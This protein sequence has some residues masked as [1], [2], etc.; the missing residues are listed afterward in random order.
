MYFHNRVFYFNDW[1]SLG[2]NVFTFQ[3]RNKKEIDD[4]KPN[5]DSLLSEY[6]TAQEFALHA[7]SI[8]WQIGSILIGGSL[9]LLPVLGNANIK[10]HI[11]FIG[12]LLVNL[13]LMCWLLFFQGQYQIKRFKLYRV[14]QIEEELHLKQNFYW[15]K[16]RSFRDPD[17]G[18]YKT[19]GPSGSDLAL[20][21][22]IIISFGY[23]LF[24][25]VQLISM[26]RFHLCIW[27]NLLFISLIIP[28]F[29][30]IWYHKNAK[31]FKT[32]I[33]TNP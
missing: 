32:Y 3:S 19:Y 33:D 31:K 5:H 14:C 17:N 23:I 22:Y 1:I 18:I 11:V 4:Q 29:T 28:I 30:L 9:V 10:P 6:Q 21:L 20:F 2:G 7:D 15:K 13:I 8:A 27:G 12:I 24:G 25:L 16:G 26:H